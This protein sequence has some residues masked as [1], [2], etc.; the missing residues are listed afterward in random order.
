MSNKSLRHAAADAGEG[1]MSKAGP[2]TTIVVAAF[3]T[4]F[5]FGNAWAWTDPDGAHTG[6]VEEKSA[7]VNVV[8]AAEIAK[9]CRSHGLR[10]NC[11][12]MAA[13]DREYRQCIIWVRG[14]AYD[15]VAGII[16]HELKNCSEG[17][18]WY[19]ANGGQA[20]DYLARR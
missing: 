8:S 13:Y 5:T 6:V 9:V 12:G 17:N 15:E 7:Q 3:L 18:G 1:K 11:R 16:A 10:A 2:V 20:Y 19:K 14:G 4:A